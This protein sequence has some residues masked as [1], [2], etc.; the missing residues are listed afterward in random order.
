MAALGPEE[1]LYSSNLYSSFVEH[2]GTKGLGAENLKQLCVFLDATGF[3]KEIVAEC[4]RQAV[5]G[6]LDSIL[7]RKPLPLDGPLQHTLIKVAN[8]METV[9]KDILGMPKNKKKVVNHKATYPDR[10]IKEIDFDAILKQVFKDRLGSEYQR[11]TGKQEQPPQQ[12]QSF[13][14]PSLQT[15]HQ[16]QHHQPIPSVPQ[17][18]LQMSQPT[19]M[20]QQFH[21]QQHLGVSYP[22]QLPMP[23]HMQRQQPIQP[24]SYPHPS[25]QQQQPR[26]DLMK[27]AKE[28]E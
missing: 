13:Q 1:M 25:Q 6:T 27:K 19:M 15:H 17:Q 8:E 5:A 23:D 7:L 12:V 21:P 28:I 3:K 16:L 11:L 20:A 26:L 10:T 14:Q 2:Y 4:Y 22:A 18:P 9:Y 24:P